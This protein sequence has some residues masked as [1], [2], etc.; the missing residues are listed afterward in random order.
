MPISEPARAAGSSRRIGNLRNGEE[1]RR[2]SEL[3]RSSASKART[4]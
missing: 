4:S 2:R 3:N 1:A